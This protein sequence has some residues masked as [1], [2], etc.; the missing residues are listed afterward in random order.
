[1]EGE[2]MGFW[3]NKKTEKK[4]EVIDLIECANCGKEYKESE[5]VEDDE[6]GDALCKVCT[7]KR[8]EKAKTLEDAQETYA[9]TFAIEFSADEE[10]NED[11]PYEY[12]GLKLSDAQT[13]YYNVKTALKDKEEYFEIPLMDQYDAD[14]EEIK[15]LYP[16][17]IKIG[18]VKR[19]YYK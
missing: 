3:D 7:K 14:E 9:Y 16:E 5:L 19:V 13:L 18:K 4:K 1:M 15:Q 10:G 12:K 8:E 6:N 11:E 17:Y 2:I